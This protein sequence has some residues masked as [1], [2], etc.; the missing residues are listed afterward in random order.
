MPRYKRIT[1][2][3]FNGGLDTQ[4]NPT[5]M[6]INRSPELKNV[7]IFTAGGAITM[8]KGYQRF[9]EVADKPVF[10]LGFYEANDI[11]SIITVDKDGVVRSNKLTGYISPRHTTAL[12]ENEEE[13]GTKPYWGSL[14]DVLLVDGEKQVTVL[15]GVSTLKL[16]GAPCTIVTDTGTYHANTLKSGEIYY[17]V[18]IQSNNGLATITPTPINAPKVDY[19]GLT[20]TLTWEFLDGTANGYEIWQERNGG[21]P[22]LLH[23]KGSPDKSYSYSNPESGIYRYRVRMVADYDGS[24]LYGGFSDWTLPIKVGGG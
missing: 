24:K 8:R 14:S 19:G 21:T 15:V 12:A 10:F 2:N 22:S 9:Y 4:T 17:E 3:E 6:E 11:R 13:D 23:A 7:D 16:F 18:E 5:I 1:L 20:V